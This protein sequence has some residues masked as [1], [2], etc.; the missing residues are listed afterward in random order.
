MKVR[1]CFL[2]LVE[3]EPYCSPTRYRALGESDNSRIATQP[4][5]GEE[6]IN[7]SSEKHFWMPLTS[8]LSPQGRGEQQLSTFTLNIER[9]ATP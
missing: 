5:R 2:S 8:I 3:C 9:F 7:A 6:R 4:L 1:D